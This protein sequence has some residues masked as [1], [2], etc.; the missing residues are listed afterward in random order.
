VS[1][2]PDL[3]GALRALADRAES[4]DLAELAGALGTL[5]IRAILAA[6][7]QQATAAPGPSEPAHELTQQAA[8]ALRPSLGLRTIRFLTRTRRVPSVPRGRSRLVRLADLDAYVAAS[9]QQGLALGV[10]REVTSAR[11][12]G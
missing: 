5:H 2:H 1:D 7:A 4:L 8:A 9:R 12:R 11:D 3:A 6:G 10:L